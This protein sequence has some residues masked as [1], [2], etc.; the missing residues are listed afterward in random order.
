MLIQIAIADFR[1]PFHSAA[2]LEQL[3][4]Q[5][6]HQRRLADA[7]RSYQS[8]M[9]SG[10]QPE[11]YIFEQLPVSEVMRNVFHCK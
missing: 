8:N 1:G 11:A 4:G 9:L 2:V 3:P 10:Q 6:I 7:I 5:N